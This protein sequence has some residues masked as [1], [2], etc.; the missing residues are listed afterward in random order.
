MQLLATIGYQGRSR[1]NLLTELQSNE[2]NLVLDIRE[3][4]WS[5]KP[6]FSKYQLQRVF[7]DHG[8]DYIHE[9]R[10]GS[11]SDIR[12]IYRETGDWGVFDA[13]YREH[14]GTLTEVIDEYA[15]QLAGRRCCLLCFEEEATLCH[16]F[17]VAEAL[18]LALG[19]D[20]LHL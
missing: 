11:P 15:E 10:L 13:A 1:E 9:P 8:I 6:G 7:Q 2:I 17:A 19:T 4:A 12:T 18:A 14:L 5:R 16:R 3:R 20:P